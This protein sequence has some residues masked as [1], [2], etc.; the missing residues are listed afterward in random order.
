LVTKNYEGTEIIFNET[1]KI[2]GN[3]ISGIDYLD[4][5]AINMRNKIQTSLVL[6]IYNHKGELIS[7]NESLGTGSKLVFKN[8]DND[9]LVEYNV[10]LYGDANGDGKINSI[11]LLTIQRHILKL[12]TFDGLFLKASNTLKDGRNPSSLDLLRIQRHILRLSVLQQ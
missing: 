9:V 10:I 8:N 5:R 6:E 1:L 3:E 4:T 7:D 11:D 12:K 2:T